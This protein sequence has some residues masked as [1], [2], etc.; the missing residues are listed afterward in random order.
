M[1]FFFDILRV[2][3]RRLCCFLVLDNFP[4]PAVKREDLSR[5]LAGADGGGGGGSL[6]LK[7][8]GDGGGNGFAFEM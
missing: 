3:V 6:D 1:C 7:E 5:G 2:F 8:C 4:P